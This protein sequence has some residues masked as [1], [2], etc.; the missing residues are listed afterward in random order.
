MRIDCTQCDMYRS[1]HCRD[2]LVTA[3][4]HPPSRPL[5]TDDELDPRLE[6]LSEAGLVPALRFRPRRGGGDSDPAAA[7]RAG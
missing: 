3:V 1:E 4:L 6:A 5:E 7:E 2:C